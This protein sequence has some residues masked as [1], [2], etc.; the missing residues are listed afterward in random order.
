VW[1]F[2]TTSWNTANAILSSLALIKTVTGGPLAGIPLHLV[3]SPKTVTVPSSGQNMIIYVVSLEFRG[4]ESQLAELGYEIA[5]KRVE[6]RVKMEQIE[7]EARRLLLPPQAESP[8]EQ[9]EVAAEFYPEA[10]AAE[11]GEEKV[12][13]IPPLGSE[14]P[15]PQPITP[16]VS[17]V[18][19]P[20]QECHGSITIPALLE[21]LKGPDVLNADLPMLLTTT[22]GVSIGRWLDFAPNVSGV[23]QTTLELVDNLTEVAQGLT[24]DD[25]KRAFSNAN[26]NLV[27]VPE[28]K[29]EAP[30]EVADPKPPKAAAGGGKGL[31]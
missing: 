13:V 31:F 23:M 25:I 30:Q 12:I 27:I 29:P 3:L 26:L 28:T 5:R 14:A 22:K 9:E 8:D 21:L 4:P 7:H 1:K 24:T 11:P 2:R 6:H 18:Q 15:E 17:E 16:P 20:A 19:E 10:A